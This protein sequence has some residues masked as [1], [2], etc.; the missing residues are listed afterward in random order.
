M[1]CLNCNHYCGM[2]VNWQ[3]ECLEDNCECKWFEE[4]E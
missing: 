1:N 4:K 2:H 3:E